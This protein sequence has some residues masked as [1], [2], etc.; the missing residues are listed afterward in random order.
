MKY[1]KNNN[2]FFVENFQILATA[3]K[4]LNRKIAKSSRVQKLQFPLFD[5]TYPLKT[6]LTRISGTSDPE[7]FN[8]WA[9]IFDSP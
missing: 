3:P 9:G 1:L 5:P 7:S 6:V 4:I 8:F 2:L